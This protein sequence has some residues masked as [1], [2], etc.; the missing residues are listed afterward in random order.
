MLLLTVLVAAQSIGARAGGATSAAST[1]LFTQAV[2][3]ATTRI[4]IGSCSDTH[5]PQPLWS[6][7][8]K[9]SADAFFWGGDVVRAPR[10]RQ[11]GV[12]R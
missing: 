8:E 6:V 11:F 5:E 3:S 10:P 9:R 1:H 7:L 2:P 12:S 4:H